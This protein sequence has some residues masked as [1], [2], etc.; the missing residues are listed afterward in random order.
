MLNP[1]GLCALQ[2]LC[3]FLTWLGWHMYRNMSQLLTL[4]SDSLPWVWANSSP[5][6]SQ[7]TQREWQSSAGKMTSQ[8]VLET[9]LGPKPNLKTLLSLIPSNQEKCPSNVTHN[10]S[11]WAVVSPTHSFSPSFP[12]PAHGAIQGPPGEKGERGYRGPKGKDCH[13]FPLQLCDAQEA[14][15]WPQR[16]QHCSRPHPLA[17]KVAPSGSQPKRCPDSVSLPLACPCLWVTCAQGQTWSS[18]SFRWPW[19]NGPTRTTRAPG[20]KR[21][22]G[23]ER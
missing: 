1:E 23:R 9:L 22:E 10:F 6:D 20:T 13:P 17:V 14:A 18:H 21:R 3:P 11:E 19:A 8:P 2:A 7:D 5:S 12:S 16:S 15:L 4:L